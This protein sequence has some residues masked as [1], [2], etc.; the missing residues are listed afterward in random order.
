MIHG[1]SPIHRQDESPAIPTLGLSQLARIREI[2]RRL[3]A[4]RQHRIGLKWVALPAFILLSAF[5]VTR[6]MSLWA[7]ITPAFVGSGLTLIGAGV[8]VVEYFRRSSAEIDDLEDERHT[9]VR[10]VAE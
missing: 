10:D 8:A 3:S 7:G 6:V 1:E 2:D 9:A 5:L 4:I